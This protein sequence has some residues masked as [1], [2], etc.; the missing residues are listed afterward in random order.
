MKS[1]T[2]GRFWSPC[3]HGFWA[4]GSEA[5]DID[6][7]NANHIIALGTNSV[8]HKANGLYVSWD[9]AENWRQVQSVYIAGDNDPDHEQLNFD[10]SS[11]DD[12]LGYCTRAYWA[13]SDQKNGIWGNPE[14]D[15]A[16]YI[17]TDGGETWTRIPD[18]APYAGGNIQ[19]HPEEGYVYAA[20][21]RGFFKSTDMG[22]TWTKTFDGKCTGLDVLLTRP[23]WVFLS[24]AEGIYRSMD[25]G[26]TFDLITNRNSSGLWDQQP[27][28]ICVSPADPDRMLVTLHPDNGEWWQWFKFYSHDGGQSWKQVNYDNK[29]A[30]LLPGDRSGNYAWHATDPDKVVCNAKGDWAGIS[31]N[32]G[33]TVAWSYDGASHVCHLSGQWSFNINDPDYVLMPMQDYG[34]CMS[35]DGGRSWKWIDL[36]GTGWGLN[37]YGGYMVNDTIAFCGYSTSWGGETEIAITFDGGKTS[38]QTGIKLGRNTCYQAPDAPHILFAGRNRSYDM[39]KTWNTMNNCD[40]V[41]S[42]NPDGEKELYGVNSQGV[43]RSFDRGLTW[44][45]V[46]RA[47]K[48]EDIAID[49]IR[50]RLY[51][52][53]ETEL[54]SFDIGGGSTTLKQLETPRDQYGNRMYN[55]VVVDPVKPDIV[56]AAGWQGAYQSTVCVIRSLDSG[57]TWEV[58]SDNPRFG[59]GGLDASGID[60]HPHT[61]FLH[62]ASMCNGN[63]KIGPPGIETSQNDLERPSSRF[64]LEQNYPNP[65][66]ISTTI[67]YHLTREGQVNLKVYD[68]TGRLVR[69]LVKEYQKAGPHRV[70]FTAQ[71]LP[72]GIYFYRLTA[73]RA[74][75]TRQMLLIR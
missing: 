67:A 23:D 40:G 62:V 27:Y 7:F 52:A 68:L 21:D 24:S 17:T 16:I 38:K 15:P 2:F 10:P 71:E 5:L 75:Q 36:S 25:A 60:V 33:K 56:Y 65:F 44:E 20:N 43:V 70:R 12:S 48:I 22:V 3:N 9:Q 32:G 73:G 47:E 29:H 14:V 6:P 31:D 37:C 69:S 19:C 63:W 74:T 58:L 49:H 34:V 28:W 51:I 26:E 42:H 66:K 72:A 57:K 1:N 50:N 59:Q 45:L 4:Q 55:S 8:P 53:R 18:T 61:R 41:Y 11:F 30:I 13:R 39:G 64:H 46:V 54:S 35:S